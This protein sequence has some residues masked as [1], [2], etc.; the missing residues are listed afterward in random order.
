MKKSIT[1]ICLAAILLPNLVFAFTFNKNNIIS[2]Q[3]LADVLD[4]SPVVLVMGAE[5]KGLRHLV[6]ERCDRLARIPIDPQM[7]SL[8]VSA[9]SAISLYAAHMAQ[10]KN[11]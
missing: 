6:G 8:N 5:G 11:R 2:D 4:G 9:A 7:E 1:L 3:D 10:T